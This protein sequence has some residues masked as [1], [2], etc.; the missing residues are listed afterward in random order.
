M[1]EG[2]INDL[3]D[4]DFRHNVSRYPTIETVIIAYMSTLGIPPSVTKLID[5]VDLYLWTVAE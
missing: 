5:L 4:A 1:I 3:C 2:F